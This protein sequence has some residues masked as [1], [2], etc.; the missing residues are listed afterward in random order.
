[1]PSGSHSSAQ[2]AAAAAAAAAPWGARPASGLSRRRGAFRGPPP[3]FYRS[4]G[5]GGFGEKRRAAAEETEEAA[6][7]SADGGGD[8]SA[9]GSKGGGFA[10]GQG[11]DHADFEV[12]HF[13]REG[14]FRRQESVEEALKRRRSV[15]E[16]REAAE[17]EA[18]ISGTWA[19]IG[20]VSMSL[21]MTGLVTVAWEWRSERKKRKGEH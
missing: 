20:I 6:R 4:G 7:R 17:R 14:H 5:W 3:S 11:R 9:A 8:G 2:A 18:E 10:P 19:R 1:M 15:W 21:I 12:P 13:D 16:E